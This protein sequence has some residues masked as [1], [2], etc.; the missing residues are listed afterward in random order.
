MLKK[1]LL[2][3]IWISFLGYAFIF[4]PPSNPDTLTLI[5]NLSTGNW[6]SINPY[7]VNLFNIMGILPIMYASLLIIDGRGQKIRATPFVIGSFFLGAFAL[8]PYLALR[9]SNPNFDGE[10]NLVIKIL[11]SR[12]LG[13]V[14]TIGASFLIISAVLTG[15]FADFIEQWQSSRFINVMSLDFCLLCLLFPTII[16]DDLKKRGI[17]NQT[18]FWVIS[19]I[20]LFGTLLYFCFRPSLPENQ[21]A[22]SQVT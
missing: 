7:I 12:I 1:V 3:L 17:K 18:V 14:I 10:K 9:Q 6:E 13:I 21:L 16:G 11:D 15:N 22:I 4:A 19:S 5:T 20:P 8:L 2:W